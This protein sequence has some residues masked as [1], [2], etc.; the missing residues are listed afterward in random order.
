VKGHQDLQSDVKALPFPAKLNILADKLATSFQHHSSHVN[1]MGPMIPGTGCHLCINTQVIPSHQ[2]HR[3]R[4]RRGERAFLRYIQQKHNLT[5]EAFDQIEWDGHCNAVKVFR[6]KSSTFTTKFLSRWLPVG[7][8][9]NRYNPTTYSSRC[10]SCDCAVEDFK[11]AFCCPAR[12]EWQSTLRQELLKVFATTNTDQA[13]QN[14]LLQGLDHWFHD[15]PQTPTATSERYNPLVESQGTIG[16]HQ[17]IF[18]R[19][20]QLWGYYQLQHLKR[21]NITI[22]HQN[23]GVGWTSKVILVIWSHFYDEW[24]NRNQALHGLDQQSRQNAR[25]LKAEYKI[26]SLYNL[27]EKCTR[28]CQLAWFYQSADEH[29]Q[30]EKQVSNLENWISLNEKRIMAHVTSQKSNRQQ[31]QYS[32]TD[33]FPLQPPGRE[34]DPAPNIDPIPPSLASSTNAPPTRGPGGFAG[35]ELRAHR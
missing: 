8:L 16:W 3:I 26:R 31:G 11:H 19:W 27:R 33:F 22:S 5:A 32:L 10:P 30:R 34:P 13:I 4:T 14:L 7:K 15:T 29:F 20:S 23:Q 6:Q 1:D 17:L 18:G 25:R 9:T 21:H 28:S 2:R 24:Q 12:Q 35:D